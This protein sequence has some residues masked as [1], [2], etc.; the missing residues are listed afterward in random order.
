MSIDATKY[1]ANYV[2]PFGVI[3]I[4]RE[5]ENG[6]LS[7][8]HTIKDVFGYSREEVSELLS[9][10]GW[11]PAEG[12][13][14]DWK[15]CSSVPEVD[16]TGL[17]RSWM[18]QWEAPVSPLTRPTQTTAMPGPHR[19]AGHGEGQ[20]CPAPIEGPGTEKEPPA[21]TALRHTINR[22]LDEEGSS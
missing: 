9:Y 18:G 15:S 16:D 21:M 19:G 5:G 6:Q 10:N 17:I 2:F 12:D 8:V 4:L 22:I 3:V 11:F 13:S 1:W 20:R 14:Y 7:I